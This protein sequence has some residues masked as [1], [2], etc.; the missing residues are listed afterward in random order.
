MRQEERDETS[1]F[2][3]SVCDDFSGRWAFKSLARGY[4]L[5]ASADSL[6]CKAKTPGDAELWFV[7]LAAR[8]QVWLEYSRT[9]KLSLPGEDLHLK[10]KLR[11]NQFDS[12]YSRRTNSFLSMLQLPSFLLHNEHRY[13]IKRLDKASHICFVKVAGRKQNGLDLSTIPWVLPI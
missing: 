6:I 11:F 13:L 8:P 3:I 5:G 12:P 7:H 10:M 1:K 2:E 9:H 4:F